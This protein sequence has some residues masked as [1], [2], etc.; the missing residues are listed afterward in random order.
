MGL[1]LSAYSLAQFISSPILGKLSDS[2]GRKNILIVSKLGTAG[3]YIILA[4]AFTYPL[5]LVSRLLDGF[6]GG[7]IAVARAYVADITSPE[8]R[9]KGMAIIGMAFGTGFILGPA[10]GRYFIRN[11]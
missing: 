5:F 11:F 10:L 6:T 3:A 9:G 2:L 8:N 4:N 1:L 7:N